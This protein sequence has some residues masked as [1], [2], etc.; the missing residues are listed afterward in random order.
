M[1]D[2]VIIKSVRIEYLSTKTD[3]YDNL[4]SFFEV[5][6]KNFEQKFALVNKEGYC[7][8]WFKGE[9]DQ[10]ILNPKKLNVKLKE[11]QKEEV[12]VVDITF[13]HFKMNDKEG[14]YISS[15]G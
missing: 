14:F 12:V 2:K 5:K 8:P 6:D 3:N 15:L 7:K 13:K 9:S 11:L 1:P 10:Y 4:K